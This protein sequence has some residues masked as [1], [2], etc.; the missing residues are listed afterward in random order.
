[1]TKRE[2]TF[3][4]Y[5]IRKAASNVHWQNTANHNVL[6]RRRRLKASALMKLY[7]THSTKRGQERDILPH[8][9]SNK[10]NGK[11]P[12]ANCEASI[13]AMRRWPKC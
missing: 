1:M 8:R 9:H 4:K 7:N 10:C 2:H 13:N 3:V 5:T 11:A 12:T 6:G